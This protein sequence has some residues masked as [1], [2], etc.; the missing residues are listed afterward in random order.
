MNKILIIDD[1][2]NL[3]ETIFELLSYSGYEVYEAENGKDGIKKI[4]EVE[5]DLILCDIMMPI[6]DGYGFMKELNKTKFS[7][8][9]VL[10]ISAKIA[11]EDQTHGMS[12]GAKGYIEK[13]FQLK[14]LIS[15]IKSNIVTNDL[16]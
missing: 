5:P 8:I 1:E 15:A 13:P 3:R 2:L 6:L 9:P 12:L 7:K 10:F 11:L 4:E 16:P 14:T